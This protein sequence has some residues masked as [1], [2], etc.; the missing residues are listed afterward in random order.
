M[1]GG[2]RV[3]DLSVPLDNDRQWAPW[4]ARNRVKRQNHAFGAKVIRW[5]L[6]LYSWH[7]THHI[8]H[9]TKLRERMGW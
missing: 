7:G 5:L 3:V 8:A 2:V 4:W 6:G 1:N 9:I